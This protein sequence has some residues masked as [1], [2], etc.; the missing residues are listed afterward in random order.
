MSGRVVG[1]ISVHGLGWN[2]EQAILMLGSV[3]SSEG[4]REK[5]NLVVRGADAEGVK[6]EV[7]S[8]DPPELKVTIGEP[9]KLREGLVHVPMEI[10]VP[11]GTRPMVRTDTAQGEAGRIVLKTT[12]PKVKELVLNVRF[13]VER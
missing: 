9:K 13:S 5:V 11:T 3:K 10:E 12:H 1:D 7:Q 4:K 2:E 6:F 8:C